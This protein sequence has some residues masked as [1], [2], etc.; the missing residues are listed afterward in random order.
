MADKRASVTPSMTTNATRINS[1]VPPRRGIF[2]D[3]HD[4]FAAAAFEYVG[5][6]FWLLIGLGGIQAAQDS[7]SGASA[8]ALNFYVSA[9]MGL[10]LLAAAWLFFRVTG[11]LFNPN[12]S[13][14]LLLV[15]GIGPLRFVLYCVAQ[16]LGAITAAAL[17]HGLLPGPLTVDTFLSEG[18]SR[19]RGV[20]IEMFITAA[21]VL[22]VLM[23]AA[24]KHATTPFAPVGVGITLFACHLFA[25]NYTGA[26]MN[27]ARSF[28]PA[29]VR[30]FSQG[31]H[32]HHWV[33]WVG[34]LL[35]SLLAVAMYGI[36][37]HYRYWQLTPHQ[38]ARDFT[39]SPP[40]PVEGMKSLAAG[41]NPTDVEGGVDG[42]TPSAFGRGANAV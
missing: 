21:L 23:L 36:L 38:A 30:G 17:V 19:T 33:Y 32:G 7:L 8:L 31:Y 16:L 10:S 3:L 22:S 24:E 15:G 28:G 2:S 27:A 29:V 34:P 42:T 11:G 1:G 5:T 18:T 40:G 26:S 13:L 14:A 25:V 20:F 4:D 12:I 41:H 35:G 39:K 9:C 37:K 6:T